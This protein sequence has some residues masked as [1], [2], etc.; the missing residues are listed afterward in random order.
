MNIEGLKTCQSR[1]Y[2]LA[3]D[4]TGVGKGINAREGFGEY[5]AQ[6]LACLTGFSFIDI[7]NKS[8]ELNT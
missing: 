7:P 4:D 2:Q 8:E 6:R 1:L 3:I 5:V